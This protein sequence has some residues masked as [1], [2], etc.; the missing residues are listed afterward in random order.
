M[1]LYKME[2]KSL[3]N[4]SEKVIFYNINPQKIKN[5]AK[6]GLKET[7][8]FWTVKK[9]KEKIQDYLFHLSQFEE[10]SH[11]YFFIFFNKYFIIFSKVQTFYRILYLYKFIRRFTD[12]KYSF[13]LRDPARLQD[14][15]A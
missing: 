7:T 11:F 4:I 1:S 8:L 10:S 14:I 13:L 2:P 9:Y 12:I 6:V 15:N 5:L 3:K